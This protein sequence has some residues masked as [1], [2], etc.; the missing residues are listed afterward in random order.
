V[1]T[2]LPKRNA[3]KSTGPPRKDPPLGKGP[4]KPTKELDSPHGSPFG[5]KPNLHPTDSRHTSIPGPSAMKLRDASS[6]LSSTRQHHNAGAITP[7][8]D[9]LQGH[10]PRTTKPPLLPY[11]NNVQDRNLSDSQKTLNRHHH[12]QPEGIVPD[13]EEENGDDETVESGDLDDDDDD[14][15]S[16]HSSLEADKLQEM[17]LDADVNDPED[18]GLFYN[19]H[20]NNIEESQYENVQGKYNNLLRSML[21]VFTEPLI[22]EQSPDEDDRRAFNVLREPVNEGQGILYYMLI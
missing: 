19:E 18:Q 5:F 12:D 4:P 14:G 16:F 10:H 17:D 11:A 1:V 13:S 9:R 21:I 15:A 22:D 20:N 6:N 8:H 2:E 3:V 7:Q